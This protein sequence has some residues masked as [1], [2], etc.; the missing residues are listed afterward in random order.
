[1]YGADNSARW[2]SASELAPSGG[3]TTTW[4]GAL[5]ESRGPYFGAATFD[6][7]SVTRPPVGSMT[8]NFTGPNSAV[9][10][11]T[12]NGANVTKNISRFSLRGII[13][14]ATTWAA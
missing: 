2:Y 14:R 11:Y 13:S 5:Y 1:M 7:G 4:T 9:L 3:G 12:V 10:Q 8:L 6:P